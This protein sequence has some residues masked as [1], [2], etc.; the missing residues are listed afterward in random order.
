MGDSLVDNLSLEAKAQALGE[1]CA[2]YASEHNEE[3]PDL[4]FEY[5]K[6]IFAVAKRS[7]SLVDT[8]KVEEKQM[9]L[10]NPKVKLAADASESEDDDDDDKDGVEE[11][12][13]E[14]PD[15]EYQNQSQSDEDKGEGED[16]KVDED[17]ADDEDDDE[18]EDDFVFAFQII[19]SCR[20]LY[21]KQE[22]TREVKGKLAKTHEL[23][24]DIA[25]ED[26]NSSQAAEDYTAASA[27]KREL[28]GA[29][30]GEYSETEFMLSIAYDTIGESEK[31][32]EHLKLA[33][34]AAKAAKL[35]AAADLEQRVAD[36]EQELRITAKIGDKN[37]KA[38][39][40]A[41]K[42][43]ITGRSAI[44]NA[45]QG[46]VSGANDISQLARKRKRTDTKTPEAE[47]QS[48]K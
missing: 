13:S 26:N 38:A 41:T 3:N 7:A 35:D 8:Q 29:D 18:P 30:S 1:K 14:S 4:L 45:V 12:K 11:S 34:E 20:V 43:S 17:G 44:Q 42:E 25:I 47:K 21:A 33:A 15:K 28:F 27:L 10:E 40:K 5:G 24:G 31:S 46:L 6:A 32:L 2:L 22:Q 16:E 39:Q 23:L 37:S 36:L 48:K 9:P 19:D